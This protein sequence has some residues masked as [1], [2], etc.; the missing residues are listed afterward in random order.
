MDGLQEGRLQVLMMLLN[1][2]SVDFYIKHALHIACQTF[3]KCFCKTKS[4]LELSV[5][6]S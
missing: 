2:Y 1:V 3:K 5:M 6:K 4:Y